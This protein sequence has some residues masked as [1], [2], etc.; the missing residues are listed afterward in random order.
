MARRVGQPG[1]QFVG[2]HRVARIGVGE[3]G[4]HAVDGL[5][6]QFQ[7]RPFTTQG[8]GSLRIIPDRGVLEFQPD[9]GQTLLLIFIVK[10][11]P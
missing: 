5:D 10:D 2:A 11:T 1:V 4:L 3:A 9:F 7:P 8:L 6:H